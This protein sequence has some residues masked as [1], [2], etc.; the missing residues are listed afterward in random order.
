MYVW[1]SNS[2]G[3]IGIE[4]KSECPD[5]EELPIEDV[6]TYVSCGYYHTALVT[7]IGAIIYI[8]AGSSDII[9]ITNLYIFEE[10]M[11]NSFL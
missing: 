3:Q 6:V 5:P 9:Y 2:E 8:V 7:G 1:G 11:L 4:G 10:N